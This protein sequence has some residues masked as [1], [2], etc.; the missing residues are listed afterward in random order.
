[1]QRCLGLGP[2]SDGATGQD[3]AEAEPEW[4]WEAGIRGTAF[5]WNGLFLAVAAGGCYTWISTLVL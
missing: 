2:L 3:Y 4:L 5:A 1:M